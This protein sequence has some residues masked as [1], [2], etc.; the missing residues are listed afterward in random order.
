LVNS[1]THMAQH[2]LAGWFDQ[3]PYAPNIARRF[4]FRFNNV[5]YSLTCLAMGARCSVHVASAFTWRLLDFKRCSKEVR[6]V[7]DNVIFVGSR[8]DVI[9]DSIEFRRRC[10]AA[11]AVLNDLHVP[12]EELAAQQGEWC[13]VALDF[14][15]KTVALTE[16][17]I[18]RTKLSWSLREH[19]TWRGFQA[20][21][22]LLFWSYGILDVS[23][24]EK[25][26]FLRFLSRVSS[27]L[28]ERPDLWDAPAKVWPS[29]MHD[30]EEWVKRIEKNKPRHVPVHVD[31]EWI[32]A[33]DASRWGWG[34]VA[35]NVATHEVRT[36]GACW[37]DEMQ[38]LHGDRLGASTFAEPHAVINAIAHV[39]TPRDKIRRIRIATD[40]SATMYSF[41]RGF[42][43]HVEHLNTCIGHLEHMRKQ[44]GDMQVELTFIK[45]ESNPSDGPSRGRPLTEEEREKAATTLLQVVGC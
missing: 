43:T 16:K 21:V 10:A 41:N 2:D 15:N 40:N 6:I 42:S 45:G 35:T 39:F 37:S 20:C 12:A 38:Q 29:A 7:I 30:M 25:V 44:L 8:E 28:Q 4:C 27:N 13:G 9:A 31:P 11:G 23:V 5:C 34:Y 22:G 36:Y 26:A 24:H 3:I 32:I 17:S 1:G 18:T 14:T 33:T 19:W